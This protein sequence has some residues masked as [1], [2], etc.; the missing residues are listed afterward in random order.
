MEWLRWWV[1]NEGPLRVSEHC[2]GGGFQF[3]FAGFVAVVAGEYFTG[4]A[5]KGRSLAVIEP[6]AVQFEGIT[7]PEAVGG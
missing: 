4:V 5:H 3:V 6:A 2:I 1:L 7:M